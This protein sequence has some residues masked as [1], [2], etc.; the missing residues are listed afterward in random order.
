MPAR[1]PQSRTRRGSTVDHVEDTAESIAQLVLIGVG[2]DHV[3]R[4]DEECGVEQSARRLP[5]DHDTDLGVHCVQRA[6]KLQNDAA[7]VIGTER[8]CGGPARGDLCDRL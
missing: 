5:H 1:R 7:C 8:H 6:R 4:S 2:C 3:A